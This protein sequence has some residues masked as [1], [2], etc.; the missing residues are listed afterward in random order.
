MRKTFL[1]ILIGLGSLLSSVW[2]QDYSF[3]NHNMVPFS[4]NPAL[5]GAANAVRFGLNYRQQWPA[6]GNKYHTVRASYDQ[7]FYKQMCS[8]GVAYS[9]DNMAAGT[10][11]VNE[12][13]VVYC[14]TF[15]LK[16]HFFIR[17]GVQ[18]TVF[19]N[20]RGGDLTFEDQYDPFYRDA[21]HN[22]ME[23]LGSDSRVYPDF[24]V[25]GAFVIDNKLTLGVSVYHIGEPKN[26]FM[27][28][29]NNVLERKF[30]GHVSW[31]KDLQYK[32]GL[33]SRSDLSSNY[34]FTNLY[35][36]KQDEFQNLLLGVGVLIS[37]ILA[38]VTFK[39]DFDDSYVPSFMAGL[40]FGSF[41]ACYV[42]DLFTTRKKKNGSW[43]HEINLIYVIRVKER[44]PCPVVY[45]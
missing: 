15:R 29:P 9:Y 41:Q 40:Q 6:L 8:V 16:E 17:L 28:K 33:F 43:S 1:V 31:F 37:P 20:F 44:Y 45:W 13:D 21:V 12:F 34:L 7:N 10:Y 4:L 24:S 35:Y 3:S 2:A 39:T 30:V 23:N 38:G 14:H 32:N 42:Y 11:Q 36:Q 18:G 22:T 5:A 25:G 27:D 26:G 19:A